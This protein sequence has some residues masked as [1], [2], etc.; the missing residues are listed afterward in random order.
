[1][2]KWITFDKDNKFTWPRKNKKILVAAIEDGKRTFCGGIFK[3][4]NNF[5][6]L[7]DRETPAFVTHWFY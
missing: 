7:Y 5:Y 4:N 1:M 2:L 3:K 6:R